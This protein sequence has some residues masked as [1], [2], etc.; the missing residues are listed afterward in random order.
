M[1][2]DARAP[3]L[4]AIFIDYD[5]IYL[6]LRRKNEDAARRFSKDAGL[7]LRALE[8]GRLVT[9]NRP[10]MDDSPRRIVS[11]RCYGNPAPR[12]NQNDNTTDMN[13]F[14]FVRHN[15]LR[16]GCEVVDCPPLTNQ[17]KNAADIR[18]VMDLRDYLTP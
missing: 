15:F 5:N 1:K 11:I 18:M 7:W 4:S 8:E 13:S 3:I 17:Q 14:S 9:A 2:R 10:V 12:R 16:A 6:S